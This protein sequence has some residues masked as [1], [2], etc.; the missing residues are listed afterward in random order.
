MLEPGARSADGYDRMFVPRRA[1]PTGDVNVHDLAV[2]GAGRD[3]WVNTR[4][5][6]LASVSEEWSFVPRWCPPFLARP[7]SGDRCHLNG[8][9]M[10]DGEPGWVTCVSSSDR[11]DGWRSGRRDQ[12]VVIDLTSDGVITTGLS[13]PHSPR[14]DG[15]RLWVANAGCGELGTVDLG[16]GRFEPVLFAP[17]FLRGLSLIDGFAVVGSS[18]PRRGDMYSG[19]PLDDELERLHEEPRL[20]VFIVDVATGRLAEWL[21]IEGPVR[22]L[23][24]V[25][26]L[27]GVRRPMAL[28]FVSPELRESVWLP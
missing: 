20:G 27:P 21:L 2:D 24:E 6:C 7:E 19:L 8:L 11:V 14:W 18:K 23:F 13:M 15:S 25:L 17:G 12:G 3:L 4:F 26:V 28:G 22:E 1:Y 16:T 10:R 5:G 9:A